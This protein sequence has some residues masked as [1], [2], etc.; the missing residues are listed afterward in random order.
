MG[1]VDIP[2]HTPSRRPPSRL[3]PRHKGISPFRQCLTPWCALKKRLC[4]SF[5]CNNIAHTYTDTPDKS[6]Y[7]RVVE[8]EDMPSHAP[9]GRPPSRLRPGHEEIPP[10]RQYFTPWCALN[11]IYMMSCHV[12]HQH[13]SHPYRHSCKNLVDN[14]FWKQKICRLTLLQERPLHALA[15]EKEGMTPIC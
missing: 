3:R 15:Q 8:T 11:K 2:P 1:T 7:Q 4:H 5:V 13:S 14:S 12:L 10:F 9:P 6:C